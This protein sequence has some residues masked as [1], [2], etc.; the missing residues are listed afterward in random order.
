MSVKIWKTGY[1]GGGGDSLRT[2]QIGPEKTSL[3]KLLDCF[4]KVPEAIKED[5][6]T[7]AALGIQPA[8]S[9]KQ[10]DQWVEVCLC[11]H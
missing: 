2:G 11:S 10:G 6:I 5:Q 3:E 8:A 1:D 9:W 7:L 4:T